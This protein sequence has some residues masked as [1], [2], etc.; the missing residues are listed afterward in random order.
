VAVRTHYLNPPTVETT[1]VERFLVGQSEEFVMH[2]TVPYL[3]FT[4][5][6]LGPGCKLDR[7]QTITIGP[8]GNVERVY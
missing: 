1:L 5:V 8:H 4:K 6:G 2:G 7:E 3:N